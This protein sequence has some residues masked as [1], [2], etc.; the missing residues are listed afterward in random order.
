[1]S[2]FFAPKYAVVKG[3]CYPNVGAQKMWVIT[4]NGACFLPRYL[5]ALVAQT[6]TDSEM[7]V[8][9]NTFSDHLADLSATMDLL[10]PII[11]VPG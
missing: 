6:D 4:R 5:D 7:V 10:L 3:L 11:L 8:V 1:M 9:D 2:L